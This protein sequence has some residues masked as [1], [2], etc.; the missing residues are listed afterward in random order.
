[1]NIRNGFP[2]IYSG[3]ENYIRISRKY[4]ITWTCTFNFFYYPFNTDYCYMVFRFK[5]NTNTYVSLQK[6]GRGILYQEST[7]TEYSVGR[8]H[9]ES[10]ISQEPYSG[11]RVVVQLKHLYASQ[12][13][14]IFIP[15]TV[16]NLI[17]YA[18][19]FFKWYDFNNCVMVS[20]TTLLV[21]MTLF[22]QVSDSLP[23]T[24]YFKLV[25]IWFF[26]SILFTFIIIVCHTVVEY[27]HKYDHEMEAEERERL[28]L[29]M[30]FINEKE[31]DKRKQHES[32]PEPRPFLLQLNQCLPCPVLPK[33][34]VSHVDKRRMK[35][36]TQ[37][38]PN[39]LAMKLSQWCKWLTLLFYIILNVAFWS[40]AFEEQIT[41]AINDVQFWE[42]QDF[43]EDNDAVTGYP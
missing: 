16:I 36:A 4:T 11:L 7:L 40:I 23:K 17:S 25:D 19:F 42:F 26:T 21:L 10:Y 34:E 38:D 22:S 39:L 31:E 33:D 30:N 1:M 8:M 32:P 43:L 28:F 12:I 9:V 41:E 3:S 13:L 15:T 5:R 14:T 20:L 24:S 27:H 37:Q 18:T 2:S 35:S 29:R 6:Y